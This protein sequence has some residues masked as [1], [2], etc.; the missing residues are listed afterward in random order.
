MQQI[1]LRH[2]DG[3]DQSNRLEQAVYSGVFECM[4]CGNCT[5]VCP[6]LIPAAEN[7]KSMMDEAEAAGLKPSTERTSYWPLL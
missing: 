2:I 4:Q 3:Q 7:I 6:A 1:Y 5:T